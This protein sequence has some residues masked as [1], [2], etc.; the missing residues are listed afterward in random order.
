MT[1][2]E[3]LVSICGP[4]AVLD[5]EALL[6]R[7]HHIW[8]MDQPLQ[9]VAVVLPASTQEVAAILQLCN[10]LKQE[11]VVHGGLTNLVGGTETQ[12]HQ[13]V[14]SLERMNT[15]EEVD[16]I[17]KTLT[18]Q[19]GVI[20]ENL[21]DAA[22]ERDLMLPLNFG[23]KGSA[24]IGGAL[25]TNAGGLRVFRFGM[26]RQLVLGLE[27][28]LPD[29]SIV[30]SLKKIIKDNSGYDLK[31][32][33][34]GSEGTLGIITKVVL[35]LTQ[36]PK[37]RSSALVG[38]E[39]YTKVL[40]LLK[41]LDKGLGGTLSGF[42]LMWQ[43]TFETMT[44]P[45]SIH[46]APLPKDYPYYVFVETMGNDPQ[47]DFLRL[48]TLITEALE[49]DIILDGVLAQTQ[50]ELN[51]IWQIRE[52]VSVLAAQAQ[53]DQHFDISLPIPKIGSIID[54][55]TQELRALAFVDRIFTFGHVADG[56]I[57]FIIGKKQNSPEIIKAINEVVYRQLKENNGSVSA[58]HGIG[59]HKKDYL[60]TSKSEVEIAIMKQLKALFDPHQILNP[61]RII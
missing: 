31:Q 9:A 20:I 34:I 51:T 5:Q 8:K 12:P 3:H 56:N 44:T 59:L 61:K 24:Q 37:T 7:Y 41:H 4:Q 28:V 23:A 47:N 6:E 1:L 18:T 39:N 32:L 15:I 54:S 2:V 27:Y 13:L 40:D 55:I 19:A 26:T 25:A 36:A 10:Q 53:D 17:S 14:L 21:I 29:G 38:V 45:P 57:H 52:D 48:E 50:R 35:R 49:T 43:H 60:N 11:V 58:E 16:P 30:S 33:L 42:E 22:A 46:T